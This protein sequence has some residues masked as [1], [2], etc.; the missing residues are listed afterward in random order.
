MKKHSHILSHTQTHTHTPSQAPQEEGDEAVEGDEKAKP[1]YG[2][3]S[4]I[5][6]FSIKSGTPTFAAL[7]QLP[8]RYRYWVGRKKNLLS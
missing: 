7:T 2:V 6:K 3:W 8:G 1:Q 4:V 5:L